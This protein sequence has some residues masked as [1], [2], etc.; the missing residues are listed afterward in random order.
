MSHYGG[1]R[2]REVT[3]NLGC[4]YSLSTMMMALGSPKLSVAGVEG[5]GICM[6]ALKFGSSVP[7]LSE[8]RVDPAVWLD[9]CDSTL[10]WMWWETA[11]IPA[12]GME[13]NSMGPVL[14]P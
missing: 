9:D 13:A 12:G 6:V 3:E 1:S 5:E 14:A 7:L 8:C 11:G 10:G 4:V 2:Q